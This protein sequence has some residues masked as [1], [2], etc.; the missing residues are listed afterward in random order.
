[1]KQLT[2]ELSVGAQ[3]EVDEIPELATRGFKSIIGNRPDNEGPDQPRW[4]EL[5]FVARSHGLQARHIPVIP[6]QLGPDEVQ[7]FRDALVELPKPI[8]AFCKTGTRST[9][10]WALVNPDGLS[11]EQRVQTAA[12][13]GY[14]ISALRPRLNQGE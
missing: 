3:L 10:L 12:E 11:Q 1:M 5:E 9:M 8:A 6:G 4:E 14:D 2:T 13:Q 7:A